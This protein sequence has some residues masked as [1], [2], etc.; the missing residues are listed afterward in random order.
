MSEATSF[1]ADAEEPAFRRYL[2]EGSPSVEFEDALFARAVD[3]ITGHSSARSS[4]LDIAVLIRQVLRRASVRDGAHFRLV[5]SSTLGP[6]E[7]DWRAVGVTAV[8]TYDQSI[9][10]QAEPW[11]PE[12]LERGSVIDSA[13]AAGTAAGVRSR[14]ESL[15][16]DP[17]FQAAT[18]YPTYRTAG[19]RAAVR[20][21][22]S[23]PPGGTLIGLLP[24]GSGKTEVA[25]ALAFL[26]RRE[27]TVIV[28]PTV[29]LAYDFERRFRETFSARDRRV[30]ADDLVFCWTSETSADQRDELRAMLTAGRLPLLVTSPESLTGALLHSV[31]AAAEGGRLRGLIVDEAHLVTQWGRDFRPEFRHLASLRH[32]LISRCV[33]GGHP[34]FRTV[35]LSA[36]LGPSELD[37]I[38]ELFGSPGPLS[39]VAANSLRP[40]PEYWVADVVSERERT[41]R[42]LEAIA[43]LP[44]PLILYVTRPARAEEWVASLRAEGYKRVAVVTGRSPGVDRREVLAGLRAG[45][46]G[47][48]HFDLVVATSAFGLGIDNDQVRAVVHACLPETLDR[49]YQEVGRS[50]RDGH[51]SVAVLLPAFGDADEAASL[52][53]TMLKPG[54]A[55]ARWGVLWASRVSRGGSNYVDLHTAPTGVD[56]GSYNRR[57][58]AQVLRGLEELGQVHRKPLSLAE[59]VELELPVGTVDDRHDWEHVQLAALDIQADDYFTTVW[60]SWRLGLLHD[61]Y[62]SLDQ[63]KAV[64]LPGA[65]ICELLAD[66]Y[67]PTES[68]A[69]RCGPAA[70]GIEPLP[71]CGRCPGCRQ[72]G[73]V[74]RIE[75]PPRG[76]YTWHTEAEELPQ[77]ESLLAAAPSAHR[78]A[79]LHTDDPEEEVPPLVNALARA[80]VRLFAGAKPAN[81]PTSW[82]FVDEAAVEP[83]DLPP[84]A[85]LVVLLGDEPLPAAWLIS[86]LRPRAVDGSPVPL[87]LVVKTGTQVGTR[88]DPVERLRTLRVALAARLLVEPER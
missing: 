70:E 88:R 49:W 40:E 68:F 87:V 50:G 15:L 46:A 85:G 61:S 1:V 77:L 73:I 38:A 32:D 48:A 25:T 72:R 21:A 36:T 34:P 5:L 84:V 51:S 18:T 67:R 54:T 31:R 53:V 19:Q 80:G 44:R 82:W 17:F 75:R 41:G 20:A 42:V 4:G 66:A 76:R 55:Q 60:E 24:T 64:L 57:W 69:S 10:V 63:M 81:P 29:A 7:N 56:A 12:W 26:A 3:A 74:A 8:R 6:T 58:N 79:L 65:V 30:A 9:M 43:R 39:V 47:A 45:R 11:T 83:G 2:Q 86:E 71:G 33:R 78:L 28:V 22:V 14:P 35:L 27:T 16:A 13:S 23:M 37:D 52:G 59:A 62:A